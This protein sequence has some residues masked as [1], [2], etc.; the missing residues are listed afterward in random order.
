[1]ATT[2]TLCDT[3]A[4]IPFNVEDP[5]FYSDSEYRFDI[6]SIGQMRRKTYFPLC[7]ITIAAI[8]DQNRGYGTYSTPDEHLL[9]C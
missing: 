8:F 3:C 5:P 1:M 6:G 4:R 9:L 2:I 7:R